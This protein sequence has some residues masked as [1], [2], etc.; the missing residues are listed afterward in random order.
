[1]SLDALNCLPAHLAQRLLDL[2][3]TGMDFHVARLTL[4]NGTVVNDVAIVDCSVIACVRGKPFVWFCGADVVDVEV[5]HRRWG[6]SY[7]TR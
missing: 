5:T 4:A 6:A 2:P 7:A 1:M 3:E